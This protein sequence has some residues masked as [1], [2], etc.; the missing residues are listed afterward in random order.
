M[1]FYEEAS[2]SRILQFRA[3]ICL[4]AFLLAA[5]AASAQTKPLRFPDVHGDKVVFSYG[6]DL[7]MASTA[8][9]TARRLT[10]HPGVEFF[11][12]FSPDGK[13]IA[14]TGQYD[15]DEQVYVIPAEGGVPRQLTYY[16]ATGPLPPRWGY[17]NQVYGWTPDGQR[18]IF[19][20]LRDSYGLITNRLYT[21]EAGGGLPVALPMPDSGAG[22]MSPDGKKVVYS[23]L[24]RDFRSWKR[25]EGG[26]A[27]DL[28]IF[29]LATNSVENIT[30]HARTD[31]D[32]MWIGNKVYFAS[33]RDGTLNLYSYDPARKATAQLT[34]SKMWDV[35]WPSGDAEGRIVYE[36]DGEIQLFH[37]RNNQDKKLSILVPDDGLNTRPAR[38]SAANLIEDFSL[39]PK[40]ERALFVARGDVFTAPIEKGPTRNLTN[41]SGA[42]DKWA[43]WSPDGKKI[44]FISD[45][46]GEEEIYLVN[47]DGVGEPERL[48][49]G[50]QAM[51]YA[52]EWSPDG[53]RLAFSDKD[54]KLYVLTIEDK[55]LVEIADEKRGQVNDYVWSG[56]GGYLAFSLS[57]ASGPNV[58]HIWS[59]TDGQTRRITDPLWNSRGPAW[60]PEGNYLY[61]LSDR[62]F[63]PQLGSFE[64]NYVVNRET[65][66]YALALRKDTKNPFAPESDEVS[67]ADKDKPKEKPEEKKPDEKKTEEAKKEYMRIDWDGLATR[68]ARV[69]VDDDNLGGLAA[70][71][72]QILYV[73]FGAGFY[74]RQSDVRP[75]LMIFSMK[76]RKSST[77]AEGIGG[78]AL[79][80]DGTKALVQQ[81]RDYKLFDVP[82]KPGQPKTVSTRGLMVDRVPS[83]EWAQIFDEVW[84]R[85]RDFFYVKN[86][87]GNDWKAI[88]NQYR[89]LLKQVAHRSDLNYIIS[90]MVAELS[91]SHAYIAGGDFQIPDR[92][93]VALPGARFALDGGSGR[94]RITK[95][96]LGQNEESIYRSPL[97]EIG[98]EAKVGDYL[99][100]IDGEELRGSDNPYRLLRNKADNPVQ[101][102][103]NDK[104]TMEGARKVS[105][106]PITNES[107]L[108]YLDWVTTNR[109][110]VDK[111]TGGRVG[112]LHL[113]DMG[114]AGIREFIKYYYGQVRKEG[115][116]VDVRGNGGGNVSQ[117]LIERLRRS[118]LGT[119]FSRTVDDATTYP[120]TVFYG[121]M[122]C[123][124][125]ETSASDGDIFPYYFRKA[126]LGPLIGK[127]SW[128][129]VVGITNRGTLIDGGQVNVPEFGTNDIDGKWAIEGHGVDPDIVVEND[130]KSVIE[131]RDPQLERGVEEVMKAIRANPKK[132]PE[133]P[134]DPVKTKPR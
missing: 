129:G 68:V 38:I 86:M 19:R 33:D 134:A 27:Q 105:F 30:N 1:H 55:K 32:P 31:R 110:K 133:R 127:R 93:R 25:Y 60:D 24:F 120:G 82:V 3:V 95:I 80:G 54:G 88:G 112:Y 85:F 106:T 99:L 76:D 59:A 5:G 87:H 14:F 53:K 72:G 7:W 37:T 119:R 65:G 104:P 62:Q 111:M 28:F 22:D 57:E 77:V 113:P 61:Y 131:G 50:G 94:Y 56:D 117:M 130:P 71:K 9:G 128:G 11:A 89:P 79:S 39:S 97:T 124:L 41:S 103:L 118:L 121:H 125:N 78:Y 83:E 36:S 70:V 51:R 75:A 45:R 18:V 4:I 66:I 34:R 90:E 81:G 73:K 91:V 23:P 8:G 26:W 123:L 15:G 115:L 48:T 46:S 17:D 16:P 132:L 92:P 35:R 69:P 109:E 42:H 96:F 49:T 84:R 13:W 20:S 47:Q 10:A 74:G 52:P 98:V 12:K 2:V 44:S 122:V 21:V 101:L 107:N 63:A 40:G 58:I 29:D 67:V 126:G 43:R 6:G 100:A 102:T 64:F 114:A 116:I 108:I